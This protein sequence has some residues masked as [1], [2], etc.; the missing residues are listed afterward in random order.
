MRRKSI[1]CLIGILWLTFFSGCVMNIN[2][3]MD[4]LLDPSYLAGKT[5]TKDVNFATN[6][7]CPGVTMP[8][9][10]V[11]IEERTEKH[12]ICI[13]NGVEHVIEPK[14]FVEQAVQ[15][16]KVK[17]MNSK[18]D[19]NE[20]IGKKI[21]VSFEDAKAGTGWVDASIV[22]LRIDIPEIKYSRLYSGK[23]S[24]FK[25]E[26]S[27]AYALHLAITAFLNDP[28]FKQYVSCQ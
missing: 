8:V 16:L 3:R 18:L 21:F 11:N 6:G 10:P 2:K 23:E 1:I 26:H 27:T 7:R 4:S 13:I 17:L 9:Y 24:S 15:Y 12:I 5:G 22:R 28:E 19:V 25:V 14:R 20:Q